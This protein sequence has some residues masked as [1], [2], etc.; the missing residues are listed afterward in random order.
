MSK[1]TKAEP[2][3]GSPH[4]YGVDLASVYLVFER[5]RRP[6]ATM[7]RMTKTAPNRMKTRIVAKSWWRL[8]CCTCASP[9]ARK[10]TILRRSRAMEKDEEQRGRAPGAESSATADPG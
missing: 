10:G 8:S 1:R 5:I 6:I 3:V 4:S 7:F 2:N 9:R